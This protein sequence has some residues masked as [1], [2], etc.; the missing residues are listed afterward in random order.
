MQK[1]EG[2][3]EFALR[4]DAGAGALELDVAVGRH[5]ATALV[6]ADVQPRC[7]RLLI[8]VGGAA[9]LC[10]WL[11]YAVA[12]AHIAWNGPL[13]SP[14]PG[15]LRLRRAHRYRAAVLQAIGLRQAR[16]WVPAEAACGASSDLR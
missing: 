9:P 11:T 14:R 4:E 15:S 10:P 7:V 3:W 13:H 8:K 1:N 16:P 2:R 12:A 5:L 6:Q